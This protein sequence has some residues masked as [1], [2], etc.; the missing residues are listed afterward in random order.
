MIPT[1]DSIL[2]DLAAGRMD[3]DTAKMWISQHLN[4]LEDASA[5]RQY[6]VAEALNGILAHGGADIGT[7]YAVERAV[8]FADE[9]VAQLNKKG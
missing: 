9:V 6:F 4:R 2:A 8:K 3:L 1:M 7:G 5:Q